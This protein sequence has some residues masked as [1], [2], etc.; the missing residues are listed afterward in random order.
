MICSYLY[1]INYC[2]S[3]TCIKYFYIS[4]P[5][6]EIEELC[7][8]LESNFEAMCYGEC[9]SSNAFDESSLAMEEIWAECGSSVTLTYR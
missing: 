6:E 5:C 8:Y 1:R 9:G 4:E 3:I 7:D 2:C